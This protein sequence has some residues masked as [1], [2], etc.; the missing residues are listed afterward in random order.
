MANSL[1]FIRDFNIA[2]YGITGWYFWTGYILLV[3]LWM[4]YHR[5]VLSKKTPYWER[6]TRIINFGFKFLFYAVY[7]LL[8]LQAYLNDDYSKLLVELLMLVLAIN[9]VG[10]LYDRYDK[11][12][13]KIADKTT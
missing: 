3:I 11:F 6:T 1:D 13:D 8:M 5:F 10:K 2:D 12:I 9:V 7:L 4:V